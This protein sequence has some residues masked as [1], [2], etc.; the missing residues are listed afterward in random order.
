MA[1]KSPLTGIWGESHCGGQ[2]GSALKSAGFD[3]LI[4]QGRS[5]SPV[6]VS[7]ADGEI[8]VRDALRLW[9]HNTLET[10]KTVKE[11]EDGDKTA[12]ACI[13]QAGE[14]LVRYACVIHHHGPF[15]AAA[16]RAGMGAVMGSKNLKAISVTGSKEIPVADSDRFAKI[17]EEAT[18]MCTAGDWGKAA[19][20]SLG[21]YG[22][23]NLVGI[24][25]EIGRFPMKNHWTESSRI[26]R[27]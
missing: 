8:A 9:G 17:V 7:V 2:F 16:G 15:T 14:N 26:M 12:V 25:N 27:Q 24:M 1:S 6:Y 19:Q 3:Y 13:G 10:T 4:I 23:P 21:K 20:D 11:N 5:R 22:T 18:A